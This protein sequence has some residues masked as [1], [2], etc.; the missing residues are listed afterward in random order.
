MEKNQL[1]EV[2]AWSGA[3]E[4]NQ[5]STIASTLVAVLHS[6]HV[7]VQME[8]TTSS[9]LMQR[10]LKVVVRSHVAAGIPKR[11]SRAI[12]WDTLEGQCLSP[13]HGVRAAA[14]YGCVSR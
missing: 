6:H 7:G 5:V 11:V 8:L 12:S 3:S 1:H 2:V 14:F 13:R 4:D 10:A 9:P